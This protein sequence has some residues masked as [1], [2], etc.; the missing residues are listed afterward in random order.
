M[1]NYK[2]C[3]ADKCLDHQEKKV[4]AF[5]QSFKEAMVRLEN[6]LLDHNKTVEEKIHGC[7]SV[8]KDEQSKLRTLMYDKKPR[9]K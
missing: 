8:T 1:V 7:I 9:H 6:N 2:F 3:N 5:E 4:F